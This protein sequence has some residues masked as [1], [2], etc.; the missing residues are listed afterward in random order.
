MR[1]PLRKFV[2]GDPRTWKPNRYHP[3]QIHQ[4]ISVADQLTT[5]QLDG[6]ITTICDIDYV[7][8]TALRNLLDANVLT[9]TQI[10]RILHTNY[11]YAELVL[12]HR[13][14]TSDVVEAAADNPREEVRYQAASS[15][16][17]TPA[18]AELLFQDPMPRVRWAISK[19]RATPEH[20]K[21]AAA[22]QLPTRPWHRGTA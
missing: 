2:A 15:P 18:L 17:L 5:E 19:N 13:H 7:A 4:L 8:R 21:V 3:N 14:T 16:H 9:P 1:E 20:L 11:T 12:S 10:I 6:L 22:L